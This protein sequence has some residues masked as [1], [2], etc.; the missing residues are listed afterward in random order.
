[1]WLGNMGPMWRSW[2]NYWMERHWITHLSP[3]DVD[4]LKFFFY[5][6]FLSRKLKFGF[7]FHCGI[8]KNIWFS[9]FH[10]K[11]K[12]KVLFCQRVATL[13]NLYNKI[14]Q[15]CISELKLWNFRVRAK[16]PLTMVKKRSLTMVTNKN[17]H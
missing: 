9:I 6:L 5:T 7:S 11:I 13:Q 4:F 1:M 17:D 15:K 2:V 3:V 14:N 16:R 10:G 8:N 12:I